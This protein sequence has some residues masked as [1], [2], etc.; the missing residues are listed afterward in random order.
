MLWAFDGI[1]LEGWFTSTRKQGANDDSAGVLALCSSKFLLAGVP[2]L[3]LE[4]LDQ[5]S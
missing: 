4:R 3:S 1:F 2:E 5:Q